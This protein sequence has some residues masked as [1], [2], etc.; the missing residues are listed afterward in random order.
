M[1]AIAPLRSNELSTLYARARGLDSA[2][3]GILM[4]EL[5]LQRHPLLPA[6]QR[7]LD[8][9]AAAEGEAFTLPGR[10][11]T[12]YRFQRLPLR[13]EP[14]RCI[15]RYRLLQSLSCNAQ[16]ETWLARRIDDV[17]Q[18]ATSTAMLAPPDE[19]VIVKR[20][21][22]HRGMAAPAGRFLRSAAATRAALLPLRSHGVTT[23]A[24][25]GIGADGH[26]WLAIT[27]VD[28]DPITLHC[29]QARLG[30]P[31][32]LQLLRRVLLAA[33]KAHAAGHAHGDLTP[34]NV[35]VT[36]DG[37]VRL[38]AF[39]VAALERAWAGN[40]HLPNPVDDARALG[41]LLYELLCG[42]APLPAP[43]V[44]GDDGVE[45]LG[46]VAPS[47][48]LADVE[49]DAELAAARG[50]TPAALQQA[51]AGPLDALAMRS[52]GDAYADAGELLAA[53]D[54]GLAAIAQASRGDVAA[55][56]EDRRAPSHRRLAV[57]LVMVLAVMLA[58]LLAGVS[59]LVRSIR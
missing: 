19:P 22:P 25:A 42:R 6:L 10:G 23:L 17:P 44:V 52:V 31:A 35:L 30:L 49:L 28:G 15:G 1:A 21:V 3:R 48:Q 41:G 39:G 56:A 2:E 53:L 32:R 9:P 12:L 7:L 8:K 26:P 54:Q 29:D 59:A 40:A 20:L 58:A 36:A 11:A 14:Q 27:P 55:P 16:A 47:R 33:A 45:S 13:S 57:R 46:P 37:G 51:L 38:C 24:D 4:I 5:A 34:T 43:G 18:G 50:L